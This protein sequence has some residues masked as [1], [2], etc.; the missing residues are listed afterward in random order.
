MSEKVK[1][2]AGELLESGE[3]K[4]FLGL[5]NKYGHVG[6]HLF[7]DKEDLDSLVVGDRKRAGDTRYS[8]NRQLI[9]IHR[10]YPDDVF[11]VL[12]RGC[13]ER[14]LKA[15]YTWNQ[16]NPQKVITVGIACPQKLADDC[17]C[18]EPF[19]VEFVDGEKGVRC[20]SDSVA[21]IDDLDLLG[22][23]EHWM[24]EFSKCV[25]CYGCRDVC[26]MCFCNECSLEDDGLI[27]PGN[28]PPE[29]PMFHLT[30]AVHMVGRCI[31]C[32]LCSEACPADIPLRT[33]YKKVA[34]IIDDEFKYRPGYAADEKSPL[35]IL[36]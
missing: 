31:D 20:S 19:P 18:L 35:N 32:G 33:L 12:V 36:G 30:R 21:R 9:N 28:I 4:G 11:G 26:P 8:L 15:L 3:I 34:D 2:R 14:G 13:D 17:E 5:S 7:C 16:L 6:P 24:N 23:F 22:R 27:D 10:R 29:T 1:E 25:K